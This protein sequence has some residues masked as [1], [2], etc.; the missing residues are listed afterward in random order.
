M[1]STMTKMLLGGF[2]GTL[3]MSL[4]MK[5]AAPMLIGQPMDIAAILG[6]MMG[7]IYA[8][9]LSVHIMLG[10]IVFPFV[11]VVLVRQLL[12]G[13]LL[14]KGFLFGTILWLSSN[15]CHANGGGRFIHVGNR[16]P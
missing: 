9:G 1:K 11:Y 4:M 12:P 2:A 14:V 8:I 6:K 5:F 13:I 16:W 7:G 15:P 10:V 3:I